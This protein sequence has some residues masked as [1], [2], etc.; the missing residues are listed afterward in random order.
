MRGLLW[1][2][3]RQAVVEEDAT[4]VIDHM[5]TAAHETMTGEY[6]YKRHN[7]NRLRKYIVVII[8]VCPSNRLPPASIVLG[9]VVLV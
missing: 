8:L 9:L 4:V 7:H 1:S 3:L 6:P 2:M 5:D